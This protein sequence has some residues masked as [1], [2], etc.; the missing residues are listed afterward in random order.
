MFLNEYEEYGSF[1]T[2]FAS[3]D[4]YLKGFPRGHFLQFAGRESSYKTTLL[5]SALGNVQK[6]FE[7]KVAY[8]YVD[9]EGNIS[10][11]YF[12][13]CGGNPE[14]T[15]FFLENTAEDVLDYVN[16]FITNNNKQEIPSL[17]IVDSVAGFTTEHEE[18]K[19]ISKATMGDVPRIINRFLRLTAIPLKQCGST[20]VFSN[21]LR[22]DLGSQ[23]GGTTTPGGRGLKHWS[24]YLIGMYDWGSKSKTY[25]LSTGELVH[26]V[27]FNVDKGKNDIVYKGFTFNMDVVLGKG[28]SKELDL[29]E[30]G[31]VNGYIDKAGH[32]YTLPDGSKHSSKSSLYDTLVADW[33][34]TDSLYRGIMGLDEER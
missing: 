13:A 31:V 16:K 30:F 4:F 25:E 8:L 10:K 12:T 21:Q 18:D 2:G 27:V 22:D 34:L 15:E 32:W 33:G 6:T 24:N 3:L 26:P 19:G 5:Q 28:F 29:I 1:F 7:D 17:V 14:M 20:V 9:T 23:F 11:D